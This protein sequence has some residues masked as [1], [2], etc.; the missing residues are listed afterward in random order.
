MLVTSLSKYT[1]LG[2]ETV[3]YSKWRDVILTSFI[4]GKYLALLCGEWATMSL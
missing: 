3:H 4:S 2:E 1:Q